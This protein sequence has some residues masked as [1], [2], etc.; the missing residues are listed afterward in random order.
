MK[1]I[2]LGFYLFIGSII[3][4]SFLSIRETKYIMSPWS[5]FHESTFSRNVI[6]Y[7]AANI[8]LG[9]GLFYIFSAIK[10]LGVFFLV[11]P[12]ML[13]IGYYACAWFVAI[14]APEDLFQ[15]NLFHDLSNSID[16]A[17]GNKNYFGQGLSLLLCTV[18]MLILVFELFASSKWLSSVMFSNPSLIHE[19]FVGS[20]V[21]FSALLYT[22]W[23]GL[24]A[25]QTT[26]RYQL[27]FVVGL[28][29]VLGYILLGESSVSSEISKSRSLAFP[30]ITLPLIAGVVASGLAA[31]STQFYSI[32]NLCASSH[33]VRETRGKMFKKIGLYTFLILIVVTIVSILTLVWRGAPD[34]IINNT[35]S[36]YGQ[37][38]HLFAFIVFAIAAVGMS[39]VVFSTVDTLL[40]SISHVFYANI[41]KLN[42]KADE[43]DPIAIRK[44]RL[45]MLSVFPIIFIIMLI[46]FYLN[47]N[48][49]YLL[50]AIISGTDA[51][52]PMLITL[53]FLHKKTR[54]TVLNLKVFHFISPLLIYLF[55]YIAA[56]ATSL[57]FALSS[58]SFTV[59][60]GPAAFLI[61]GIFSI[62]LIFR[63]GEF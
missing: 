30:K 42:S 20:S 7:T 44:I 43:K 34:I 58:L 29:A 26:D 1:P 31:F 27:A 9:T 54:L 32:L 60:V 21:F 48:L 25:V 11:A 28:L 62:F 4:Y 49:F 23:G 53:V 61:S 3:V 24:R 8:T 63:S 35:F 38:D 15:E 39:S 18:F 22:L 46:V 59:Y 19:I 13:L 50:L 5:F 55:I 47:P 33:Q 10:N 6:S 41:C 17:T 2:D 45:C 12:I 52:V 37:S 40:L 57:A 14:F 16:E 51:L 56:F 36:L